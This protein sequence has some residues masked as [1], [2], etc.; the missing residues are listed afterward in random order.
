MLCVLLRVYLGNRWQSIE[1]FEISELLIMIANEP[2]VLDVGQCDFDQK[3][4]SRMLSENL[5]QT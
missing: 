3:N 5:A 4:I 2:Q 1:T